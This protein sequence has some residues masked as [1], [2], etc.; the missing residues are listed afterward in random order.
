[1]L[2]IVEY[3]NFAMFSKR[4]TLPWS[5]IV[6]CLLGGSENKNKIYSPHKQSIITITTFS[7]HCFLD[8]ESCFLEIFF[9]KI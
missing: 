8:K 7:F 1:M 6:Y 3:V 2:F 9:I 4:P 5:A